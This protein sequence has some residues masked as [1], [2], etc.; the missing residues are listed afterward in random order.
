MSAGLAGE[1]RGAE[2]G[3]AGVTVVEHHRPKREVPV[4][5]LTL[6]DGVGRDARVGT[7]HHC[8]QR[9]GGGG[10]GEEEG[11]GIGVGR[12]REKERDV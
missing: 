10:G 2:H 12:G 4:L 9:R 6:P 1:H 3:V 8:R 5:D 7:V 11:K